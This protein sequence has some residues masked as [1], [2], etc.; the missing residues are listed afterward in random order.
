MINRQLTTGCLLSLAFLMTAPSLNAQSGAE[1]FT[2][3][4][5][6]KTAASAAAS[7][8]VTIVV[9]RKTTQGEADS[10]MKAFVSG[11]AAALRTALVGV[12]PTGSVQLG[13]S[14]PI[15][16]RITVER[17][18]DRGRLLTIVADQPVLFLGG[19][20]PA[21]A[22]REGYDFAIID[23]EVDATGRGSGTMAPAAKV[24]AKQGAF[25]VEDY[26]SE[27]LVLT[28]VTKAK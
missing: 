21:A 17:A 25:V 5:T 1:T 15:S 14:A 13:A 20:L 9:N 7:A 10:L 23:L 28:G 16:T 22:P 2:A 4:A 12:A 27:L 24:T 19:S 26:A 11:G 18:T 6:V 8:P 3:T